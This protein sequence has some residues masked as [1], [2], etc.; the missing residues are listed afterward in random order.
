MVWLANDVRV[1]ISQTCEYTAL[2]DKG[3]LARVIK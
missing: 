2:R 3:D 1:L